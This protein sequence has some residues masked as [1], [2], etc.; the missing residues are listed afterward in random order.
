MSDL[1]AEVLI[2]TTRR[3]DTPENFACLCA[4]NGPADHWEARIDEPLIRGRPKRVGLSFLSGETAAGAL[5]AAG[6]F[7][8]YE[9][10]TRIGEAVVKD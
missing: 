6:K 4:I 8:L 7:Y 3:Q 2:Y 9:V 5:R 1:H 10:R